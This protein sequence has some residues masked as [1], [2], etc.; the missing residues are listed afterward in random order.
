MFTGC[1]SAFRLMLAT[2]WLAPER[3][4]DHQDRAICS[5]MHSG[6]DWDE[7]LALVERHGTPALSWEVL[8]RVPETDLP[9][10][11]RQ[12]LQQRSAACRMQAVRLTSLLMQ[13]LK[14]LSQEGIPLIPLK[15]PLLSLELYG[16]LGIRHSQDIDIMVPLGDMPRA[17]ARLEKMGWRVHLQP[18]FSPRHTEVFLKINHHMIYW[19]PVHRYLL[20][21]HWRPKWETHDRIG[22]QWARSTASVWNGLCYRALSPVDL[23]LQ[24]CEH[25]SGHAWFRSKWLS[26][27]ARM[28]AA[29]YVD[30]NA[31][32]RTACAMGVENS[33]LQCLRLLN[34]LYGLP[35]PKALSDSAGR[36]PPLLLDHVAVCMLVPPWAHL[37][38]L[39]RLRMTARRLRYERLLRPRR[40]WRQASTEIAYSYFDFELLR[41][42]D[43]LF[44]LYVPL[45][46]FLFA[47]RWLRRSEPKP[48]REVAKLRS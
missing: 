28:Y 41:L 4:R 30:W 36:L 10:M 18:T 33:P 24:L 23:T 45:R 17:Q 29:N 21:L 7:Y 46:P 3:W 38:P 27:L 34:E 42:P 6:P 22:G 14:D 43:R 5:A 19:H 1:S 48:H 32:Y 40:S 25:G 39:A 44:G 11:V 16:D 37:S 13:V 31:V 47:W 2:S 15:G 20:E 9:A 35:V 26:D 8:K 12:A